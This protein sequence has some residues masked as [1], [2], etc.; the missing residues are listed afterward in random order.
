MATSSRTRRD[1][2]ADPLGH[3]AFEDATAI[4]LATFVASFGV[5]LLH[6]AGAVTGGTA[7]LALLIGYAL[8]LPFGPV[9]LVLNVP[10]LALAAWKR[11]RRFA[12]RTA[13]CVVLVSA[14]AFV[15]T[16]AVPTIRLSPL[17]GTLT[18]DLLI[19]IAMLMLFRHDAS[20][21]GLNTVALLAQDRLG[22]RAGTVQLAL[23]G[24]IIAA[25]LLIVPP[26]VVLISAA[27][28]LVLN[29]VIVM[30]HRPGRYLGT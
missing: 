29:V 8:Q 21:G 15:H 17:Y 10:F 13:V 18:G 4:V 28:A 23:D 26:L 22:V 25:S 3:T 19:G 2:T 24:A 30:N 5:F 11:G 1:R 14:W 7:G 9:F 6:G 12:V 27:G 16:A 20:L